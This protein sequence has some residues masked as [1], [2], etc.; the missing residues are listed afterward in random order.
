MPEDEYCDCVCRCDDWDRADMYGRVVLIVLLLI[1]LSFVW[2][3]GWGILDD[4]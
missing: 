4:C 2:T 3:D 1:F